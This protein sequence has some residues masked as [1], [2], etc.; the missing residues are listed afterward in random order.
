VDGEASV[1]AGVV[2]RVRDPGAVVRLGLH[3]LRRDGSGEPAAGVGV[4]WAGRAVSWIA[5]AVV[6][7]PDVPVY[8]CIS[9]PVPT[10]FVV[11][12]AWE[13][14]FCPYCARLLSDHEVL[15]SGGMT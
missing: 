1:A 6:V 2:D 12:G 4:P 9:A 8:V 13:G 5:G 14:S 11:W 10:P 7:N 3:A 15:K